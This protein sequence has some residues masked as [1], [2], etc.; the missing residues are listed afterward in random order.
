MS[1]LPGLGSGTASAIHIWRKGG[2]IGSSLTSGCG[3][4][5][6]AGRGRSGLCS[7][8]GK[9]RTGCDPAAYRAAGV[10]EHSRLVPRLWRGGRLCGT[11]SHGAP[12]DPPEAPRESPALEPAGGHSCP[13]HA[14]VAS[15]SDGQQVVEAFLQQLHDDPHLA[16]Q[17]WTM[18]RMAEH[19]GMGTTKFALLCHKL[20]N[21]SPWDYLIRCRL[22]RAVEQLRRV[23]YLSITQIWLDC[24]FSSGQ[25][26]ATCFRQRHRC[27]PREYRRTLP[28]PT[29]N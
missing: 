29:A 17:P 12:V 2:S 13:A 3:G 28:E 6:S 23:P 4:R 19:C 24:G 14:H 27:T 18:A 5:T 20:A 9:A 25:H 11:L 21:S 22:Q 10:A 15:Q 7:P 16:T 8:A 1:R 26:F